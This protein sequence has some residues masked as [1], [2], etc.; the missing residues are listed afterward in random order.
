MRNA[1]IASVLTALLTLGAAMAVTS[2]STNPSESDPLS[3]TRYEREHLRA[4]DEQN[5]L[6]RDQNRL[7]E[8]MARDCR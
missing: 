3:L 2:P 1:I 8:R 7:L 6:L 4:F 5:R